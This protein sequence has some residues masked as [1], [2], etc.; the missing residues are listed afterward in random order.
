MKGSTVRRLSTLLPNLTPKTD[1]PSFSG[2]PRKARDP[3]PIPHRTIP[4][5]KGR[6]FD[7]VSVASSHLIHS[8]W[9]KLERLS[10][11]FTPF[12]TKHV[13][14]KIQRDYVLSLEF[15]NWVKV[16]IPGCHSRESHSILLHVLTKNGKFKSA[17]S[18][19]RSLTD[20]WGANWLNDH[21]EF[22]HTILD[23]YR[24][25]DSSPRVLDGIFKSYS[26][27][28]KLRCATD[29]FCLMKEYGMLPKIE[30]CNA[31]LSASLQ[32][33][34]SDIMLSFY[35]EMR[36][37]RISPN[38]YTVNMIMGAY[39]SSGNVEKAVELFE[40]MEGMGLSQSLVSYNTLISGYCNKGLTGMAIKLKD[41]MEKGGIHPNVIT[42]NTLINGFRKEAKLYEANRIIGEMKSMKV[43]PNTITY[44]SLIYG[45]SELGNSELGSRF[46]EDME[47]NGVKADIL[48]YNAL[49]LGFCKEGKTKKAAYLVKELDKKNLSPNS[50]T[51]SALILGQ[52]VR[53]NP[54]RG[55]QLY[56]SMKRTG[57]QP[58]NETLNMLMCS[59]LKCKDI[60]G[61]L[62]V[63][64][65]M[66]H[67]L[68][69]P[70]ANVF[71]DLC[72]ELC[73][74]GKKKLVA[75]LCDEMEEKDRI[76]AGFDRDQVLCS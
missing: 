3:L 69:I 21:R 4:E 75:D 17:D 31:F 51:F 8:D 25:C 7:F 16:R 41:R 45:C 12:R 1:R 72:R 23:T 22:L 49:I 44:N 53:N 59:F 50:S 73:Q 19:M 27:M 63:M 37:C 11:D 28:K 39:C 54:D 33:G 52:C 55:F 2:N 9:E 65:E 47:K 42:F 35:R 48:T 5:P 26:H 36:R 14:L 24:A 30:S 64:R 60:D 56:K 46:F 61:A 15:F 13:L 10:S 43:A 62:D 18:V 57:C 29:A 20:S 40:G 34:R 67:L 74:Q 71:L 76:P 38:V 58:N 66:L 6:D 68:V 70:D 32:M